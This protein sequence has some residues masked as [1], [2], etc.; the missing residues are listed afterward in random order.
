MQNGAAGPRRKVR[1]L[2]SAFRGGEARKAVYFRK[3][4]DP[5]HCHFA[6]S[7]RRQVN[8]TL[9]RNGIVGIVNQLKIRDDIFNF[10]SIEEFQ[11]AYER[12]RNPLLTESALQVSGKGVHTE[13]NRI[14]PR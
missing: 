12:E 7:A 14:I 2:G 13:K 9:K 4:L 11:T 8:H 3:L 1:D 10:F 5:I 6:D